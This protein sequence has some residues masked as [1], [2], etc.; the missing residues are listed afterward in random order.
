MLLGMGQNIGSYLLGSIIM[1]AVLSSLSMAQAVVTGAETINIS[2]YSISVPQG[3][4]ANVTFNVTLT[5]GYYTFGTAVYVANEQQ[6]LNNSITALI[7][8]QHPQPNNP[9]FQGKLLLFVSNDTPTGQYAVTLAGNS[10]NLTVKQAVLL[11][12]VTHYKPT[13]T[14]TTSTIATTTVNPRT[15]STSTSLLSSSTSTTT[16][17][18]IIGPSLSN[19]IYYLVAVV[20]IVIVVIII[21]MFLRGR[22]GTPVPAPPPEPTQQTG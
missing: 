17:A 21:I 3:N 8:T 6:L 7:K 22:R 16:V 9:P 5:G 2:A 10:T 13:T 15:I 1:L 18:Q 11:L 12:Y 14:S 19:D 20:A 4:K